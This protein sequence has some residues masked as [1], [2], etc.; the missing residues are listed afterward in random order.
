M[1]IQ[2]VELYSSKQILAFIEYLKVIADEKKVM[3]D[4]QSHY[5][6]IGS[7]GNAQYLNQACAQ[8]AEKAE[9]QP[10]ND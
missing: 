9:I 8:S 10:K 7:L 5:N 1:R 2:E 3:E 6:A 4:M